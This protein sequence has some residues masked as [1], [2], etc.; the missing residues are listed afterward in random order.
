MHLSTDGG[1]FSFRL[2]ET[3]FS[4]VSQSSQLHMDTDGQE[5][6]TFKGSDP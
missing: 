1:G 5:I 6:K 3:L 4:L 2:Q